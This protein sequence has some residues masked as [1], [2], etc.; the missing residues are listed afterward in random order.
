MAINNT[1]KSV[2]FEYLIGSPLKAAIDAQNI[3]TRATID[4]IQQVGFNSNDEIIDPETGLPKQ[5]FNYGDAR[6][7]VFNY[8]RINENGFEEISELSIPILTVVP[9]PFLRISDVELDL[10]ANITETSE[11]KTDANT[12]FF[13]NNKVEFK[14]K[15]S[16]K[17][18]TTKSSRFR[19][20]TSL[21]VKIK[22][23]HDELPLGFSKMLSVMESSIYGR[24]IIYKA[25]KFI[26]FI[27]DQTTPISNA[28]VYL[29][30][31]SATPSYTNTDGVVEFNEIPFGTYT[32]S[33]LNGN[34]VTNKEFSI[35]TQTPEVLDI[36]ITTAS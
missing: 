15:I 3:A 17:N 2:P 18:A 7:I 26:V 32:I 12:D 5:D 22:A 4:F 20:E 35:N 10:I 34:T 25:T 27:H 23:V 29:L 11:S 36:T 13:Y 33:I 6:N 31:F 30:G 19:S 9:V 1:L 8:I 24:Q 21:G 16:R 14:G 28:T